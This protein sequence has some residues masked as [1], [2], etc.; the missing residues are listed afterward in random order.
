MIYFDTSALVKRYVKER[1]SEKVDALLKDS[2]I[3]VTSKL[4]YPEMLSAFTRRHREGTFSLKW[5]NKIVHNF[6]S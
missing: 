2:T 6:I 3:V 1:G 5:L 4:T